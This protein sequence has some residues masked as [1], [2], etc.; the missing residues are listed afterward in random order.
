MAESTTGIIPEHL[1]F[2]QRKDEVVSF[3][4]MQ[5]LPSWTKR[6]LLAGWAVTVGVFPTPLDYHKVVASGI[7]HPLPI[8]VLT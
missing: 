6:N 7:D 4:I 3:L 8:G 2:P 5:P 1:M